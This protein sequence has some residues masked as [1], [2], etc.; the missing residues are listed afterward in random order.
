[1]G[2]GRYSFGDIDY[3]N[4]LDIVPIEELGDEGKDDAGIGC[5][6]QHVA[7]VVEV[8]HKRVDSEPSLRAPLANEL[9]NPS[10]LAR[11]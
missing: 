10:W 1:M 8:G 6:D 9:S 5:L 2:S 3:R 11:F 7:T 4:Y